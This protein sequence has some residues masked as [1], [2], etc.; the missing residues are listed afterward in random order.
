ME[1]LTKALA[2]AGV[3]S[4]RSCEKLIQEGKVTV[5]GQIVKVPYFRIEWGKDEIRVSGSPIIAKEKKEYYMVHKPSGYLCTSR[6]LGK[7]KIVLD[8][9]PEHNARLFTV[10]RLDLET[11]GLILVTN[12]GDFAHKVQHP[13]SGVVKEYLVKVS[14]EVTHEHLVALSKGA[15]VEDTWVKPTEVKKVRRGTFKILLS[16][17]KKHEVRILVQKA[18]LDLIELKRIRIGSLVLGSLPV[19]QVRPLTE[20]DQKLVMNG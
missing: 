6:R 19:G 8:L 5:N 18:G 1:R 7:K 9:F 12:D 15:L 13:S 16:E 10:G 11:T 14:Q 4:R 3:A 17:G 20:T 2:A